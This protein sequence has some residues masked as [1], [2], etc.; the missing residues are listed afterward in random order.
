LCED[1]R[2]VRGYDLGIELA[3]ERSV[4]SGAVT[5]EQLEGALAIER[6]PGFVMMSPL[7]VSLCGRV[8]R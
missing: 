4:A 6:R 8:Q 5:R 7:F 1:A 2:D 3:A